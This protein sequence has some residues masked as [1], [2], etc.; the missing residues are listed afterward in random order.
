MATYIGYPVSS[1][2]EV[3]CI[4]RLEY[5]APVYNISFEE[6]RG[7]IDNANTYCEDHATKFKVYYTEDDQY[8]I[9]YKTYI[10]REL[11]SGYCGIHTAVETIENLKRQFAEDLIKL[12]ADI[13][14]VTF[15]GIGSMRNKIQVLAFMNRFPVP[16][17]MNYC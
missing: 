1:L 8:I 13:S 12:N 9:G 4:L 11:K 5:N 3:F 17:V 7:L 15:D 2:P 10:G 16:F 6:K 14:Q